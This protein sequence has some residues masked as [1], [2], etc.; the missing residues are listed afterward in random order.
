MFHQQRHHY[1]D[2]LTLN[3]TRSRGTAD[4]EEQ[5]RREFESKVNRF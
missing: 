4:D 1:A 5:Y 2:H 3:C